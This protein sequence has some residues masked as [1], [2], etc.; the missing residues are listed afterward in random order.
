MIFRLSTAILLGILIATPAVH[1]QQK[2][3]EHG[4]WKL[5]AAIEDGHLHVE[6]IAPGVDVVGFEHEAR[7]ASDK[8]AVWK[9]KEK[10]KAAASILVLPSAAECTLEEAHADIGG[11]GDSHSTATHHDHKDHTDSGS[12]EETMHSE[13]YAKYVFACRE[14]SELQTIG[15]KIFDI[16]PSAEEIEA[17]VLTSNGQLATDLNKN[18]TI[19]DLSDLL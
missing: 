5:N 2:P 9:A 4:H 11:M 15:V 16:F 12:H 19:I 8:A 6:L 10:L 18:N 7:T 3:H 17:A 1:A 13:F 14:I